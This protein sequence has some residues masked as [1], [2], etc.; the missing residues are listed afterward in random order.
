VKKHHQTLLAVALVCGAAPL[1]AGCRGETTKE[2][3]FVGIRG[4]YD[5]PRYNM[6]EESAFFP[7]KRNMR[8]AVEGAVSR[9]EELDEGRGHGRLDD[10]SGYVLT[11]P[12]ETVKDAGGMEAL[13]A[14]GQDRFKIYCTPCHDNTGSGDGM[15][16]RRGMLKP[17]TFH[18]DRL[19][20][21]PDG[22]VF[23]TISN[24][25]RNMPAYGP[26]IPVSDRWAI[27]GYVRALQLS[28][29]QV[30]SETKP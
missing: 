18:Q 7:D 24:G 14:R 19:R 28:Q 27:V 1:L 25:V 26:Q 5:Q 12:P 21:I 30:A 16:V 11:I 23:A 8:P 10:G 9:E 22:Q 13:V 29:A 15:A 6:Q 20:H 17:P 2:T 4:M 3:P